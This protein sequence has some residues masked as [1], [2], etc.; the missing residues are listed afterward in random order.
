[1][2]IA[3]TAGRNVAFKAG[4]MGESVLASQSVILTREVATPGSCTDEE[5]LEEDLG[6][7]ML[8]MRNADLY[9]FNQDVMQY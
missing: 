9:N 1:M 3:K 5:V 2:V 7:E 4:K 6:L 8:L